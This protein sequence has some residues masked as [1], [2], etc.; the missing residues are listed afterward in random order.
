MSAKASFYGPGAS[1]HVF[2]GHDASRALAKGRYSLSRFH[3]SL[4]TLRSL[5][6]D[7]VKNS[8]ISDLSPSELETLEDWI[9]TFSKYPVVGDIVD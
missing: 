3:T 6:P 5:N 7:D 4:L 2:T 8:D 1:Y 9:Q